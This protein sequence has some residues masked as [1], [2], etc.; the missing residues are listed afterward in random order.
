[1]THRKLFFLLFIEILFAFM[2]LIMSHK[3]FLP[4]KI[5]IKRVC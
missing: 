3:Y 4:D 1:M 2:R 5:L